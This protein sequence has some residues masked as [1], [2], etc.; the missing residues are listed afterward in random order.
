[1]SWAGEQDADLRLPAQGPG[2]ELLLGHASSM[3]PPP[4]FKSGYP[5]PYFIAHRFKGREREMSIQLFL[6]LHTY[7]LSPA[8]EM[9]SPTHWPNAIS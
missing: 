9:T 3:I 7:F 6:G 2:F 8:V 4:L 5:T 1:M